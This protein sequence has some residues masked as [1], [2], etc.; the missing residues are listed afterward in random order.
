VARNKTMVM[1]RHLTATCNVTAGRRQGR[2]HT[3]I[4]L[5]KKRMQIWSRTPFLLIYS[6][7]CNYPKLF[8]LLPDKVVK[9]IK[10]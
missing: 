4:V 5:F 1:T 7:L 9:I 10:A 3:P 2:K 6:R 8:A